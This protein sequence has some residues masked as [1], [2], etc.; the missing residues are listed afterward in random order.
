MRGVDA[1]Q[2]IFVKILLIIE[3]LWTTVAVMFLIINYYF[4]S[5]A[6]FPAADELS[7]FLLVL[8]HLGTSI[9]LLDMLMRF[10]KG[11]SPA[12]FKAWWLVLCIC[13]DLR[14]ILES[15]HGNFTDARVVTADY[16]LGMGITGLIITAV[17]LIVYIISKFTTIKQ[18]VDH[19][20][21]APMLPARDDSDVMETG[22]AAQISSG[23]VS[24]RFPT[25]T[26]T[27]KF[28]HQPA[29]KGD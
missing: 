3:M 20:E 28:V 7:S 21:S 24:V 1:W 19:H 4:L 11:M 5:H 12:W 26:G 27:T 17:T 23:I 6:A 22:T 15:R 8:A 13:F 10:Q 29:R 9:T 18:K 16:L 25:T 14:S 2:T